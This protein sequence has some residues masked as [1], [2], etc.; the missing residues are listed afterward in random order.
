MENLCS[1]FSLFLFHRL[2]PSLLTKGTF[3][4]CQGDAFDA[5]SADMSNLLIYPQPWDKLSV[6]QHAYFNASELHNSTWNMGVSSSI[7]SGRVPPLAPTL[8]GTCLSMFG[9]NASATYTSGLMVST[10]TAAT[11]PTSKQ[12]CECWGCDWSPT[13]YQNFDNILSALST[14][15]EMSTTEGWVDIMYAACDNRGVDMQ[16]VENYQEGW[17]VFF[18]LFIVVGSF[19][20]INLF[21][22]LVIENFNKMKVRLRR[23]KGNEVVQFYR[24]LPIQ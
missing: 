16:P 20:F 3:N 17:S 14:L 1:D 21:I 2:P 11:T 24:K 19:F 22:G 18:V 5:L 8:N 15:W 10:L 9:F 6:A 7:E 13:L 12:L 23:T 4:A